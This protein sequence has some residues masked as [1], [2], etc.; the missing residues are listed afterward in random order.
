MIHLKRNIYGKNKKRI[1]LMT[2]KIKNLLEEKEPKKGIDI[3]T[4]QYFNQY[5]KKDL[6]KEISAVENKITEDVFNE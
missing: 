1:K 2:N 6:K 3:V 4:K 5:I